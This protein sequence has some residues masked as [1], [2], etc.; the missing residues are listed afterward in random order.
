MFRGR[1]STLAL[2]SAGGIFAAILGVQLGQSAISE[3]NPIHFQG[4][5]ERPHGIT[6][7]PEPAPYDPYARDYVW[8]LPP[9]PTLAQCFGDCDSAQT[10]EAVRL[11]LDESAG[12]DRALPYWR[13]ATPTTELRPW[14]PG[15]MPSA[16]L[17]LERYMRYPVNREQAE[18]AVAE[19][20]QAQPPAA[21][22]VAR[23]AEALRIPADVA[24]PVVEE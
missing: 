23:P 24:E 21:A 9:D 3:I 8:S 18:Q 11:A 22:A 13:D 20:A 7:P 19:A 12:R 10:S 14:P 5:L 15:E 1:P 16:G 6:P 17:S 4:A 2:T